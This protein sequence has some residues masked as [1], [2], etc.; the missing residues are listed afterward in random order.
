MQRK[1]NIQIK[2]IS[3][4]FSTRTLDEEYLEHIKIT[5]GLGNKIE[6][7]PFV[8]NS[9]KSLTEIYNEGLAKAKNDIVVFCHDDLIFNIEN[10]AV[11]IGDHFTR[12]LG[13]GILGIAGTNKLVDGR[14]WTLK[15]HMHGI[16]NHTDGKKVWTSDYSKP[17][18]IGLKRMVVLDGLL[19]AVHK[20]RIKSNFDENVKGF[21]FYDLNFCMDNFLQGVKIGVM[22]N[23]RVT[24]LSI[25]ETNDLWEENK[26][27]FEEK[28]KDKLPIEI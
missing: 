10:W 20:K 9:E 12:N 17:Q 16:V 15:E 5:S 28:Y 23:V 1:G 14:W 26:L 25:G 18:G 7:L 22:T 21:H 13:F 19:I 6:I 27:Q 11:A 24:H 8:N 3:V 4:V 2:K